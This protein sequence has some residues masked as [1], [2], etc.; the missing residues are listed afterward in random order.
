MH[1]DHTTTEEKANRQRRFCARFSSIEL[2]MTSMRVL[3]ALLLVGCA[4]ASRSAG[5]LE[6]W[7]YNLQIPI[8]DITP[9]AVPHLLSR[10][11]QAGG[12]RFERTR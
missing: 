6:D 12:A 1:D 7:L 4:A 10:R 2:V 3:L 5:A 11:I 9:D 8:P